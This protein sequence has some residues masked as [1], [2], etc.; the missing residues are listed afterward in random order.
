MWMI[1]LYGEWDE[2]GCCFFLS[3]FICLF[4]LFI[5]CHENASLDIGMVLKAMSMRILV[6]LSMSIN[7]IIQALVLYGC[8]Y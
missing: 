1:L 5:V 6:C 7:V 3:S 2:C 4:V 8:G